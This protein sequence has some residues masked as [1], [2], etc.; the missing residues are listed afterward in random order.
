MQRGTDFARLPV[1]RKAGICIHHQEIK[2]GQDRINANATYMDEL[3]LLEGKP[4]QDNTRCLKTWSIDARQLRGINYQ[5]SDSLRDAPKPS[6][7]GG[8]SMVVDNRR[9]SYKNVG[10]LLAEGDIIRFDDR[11]WG[12]S[13][14][15]LWCWR[16]SRANERSDHSPRISLS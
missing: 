5:C 1:V 6:D 14:E 10:Y 13:L 8:E 16:M 9:V 3:T 7:E 2:D 11:P 15:S 4:I 12:E